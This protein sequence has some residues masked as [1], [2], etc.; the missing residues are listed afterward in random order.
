MRRAVSSVT[1]SGVPSAWS[2]ITWNSLLLSKGSILNL[3]RRRPTRPMDPGKEGDHDAGE[4]DPAR[5]GLLHER[6]ITAAV[7]AGG[8]ALGSFGAGRRRV[9]A[10]DTRRRPRGDHEGDGEGEEHGGGRPDRDGAHVR[11][12]QP[13]HEGHGQDGRDHREGGEDRGVAHLV[14]RLHGDA[15][16]GRPGFSRW[17]RSMFSTTTMASSTRMPMEK[18]SAKRVTRFRV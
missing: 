18:I 17:W 13:A 5:G 7:E 10:E 12:R 1:S 16:S 3:T 2:T 6:V 15:R 14:H 11:T 8:A 9:A 4:K